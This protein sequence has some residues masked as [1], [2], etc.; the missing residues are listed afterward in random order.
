[1]QHRDKPCWRRRCPALCGCAQDLSLNYFPAQDG[2]SRNGLPPI[3][4]TVFAPGRWAR[5]FSQRLRKLRDLSRFYAKS[6][7]EPPDGAQLRA[8]AAVLDADDRNLADA[9]PLGEFRGIEDALQ[10]PL[11]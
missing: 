2:V 5:G 7:A 9:G 1:M 3:N 11:S 8:D 10:A 6:L 4:R